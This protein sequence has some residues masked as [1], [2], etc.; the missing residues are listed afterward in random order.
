MIAVLNRS[1]ESFLGLLT[2]VRFEQR[3]K[4]IVTHRGIFGYTKQSPGRVRPCQ[5]AAGQIKVP[6][7]DAGSFGAPSKTLILNALIW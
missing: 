4:S 6:T 1:A 7:A 2:V 3:Q 5:F